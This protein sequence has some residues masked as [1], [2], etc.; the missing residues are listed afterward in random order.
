M[1]ISILLLA[2]SCSKEK[3]GHLDPYLYYPQNPM[4]IMQGRPFESFAINPNGSTR[5]MHVELVHIYDKVTG[6]NM[7]DIFNQKFPLKIWTA[8]YDHATDTTLDMINAIRKIVDT[9][10]IGI[11]LISGQLKANY[12]S[13]HLPLGD[14]TFDVK[15]SNV[16]GSTLY[17]KLGEFLLVSAPPYQK[18][19]EIGSPYDKL[20][21]VGNE[22]SVKSAKNP[23]ITIRRIA[24][25]PDV[26][27]VK[28]V[29][30]MGTA[31]NPK[32][33][34]IIKR[35]YPG[36]NPPQPYLQTMDDYAI[37][38]VYTDTSMDFYYP[39]VPFP[40]RSLGNGYNYYYRVPTRYAHIDKFPD[41]L[42]SLNPRFVARFFLPGAYEVTL[43]LPDVT[44]R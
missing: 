27:I 43:Q 15:I 12:N 19:P 28:F 24:D 34:E 32:A 11:D 40:V 36:N 10:A 35:P 1:G 39:V 23:I 7:D 25:T 13:Y 29:D 4:T 37:K 44:H 22:S 42:Y 30:K 38:H 6:K 17:P 26:I 3:I 31:F 41:D 14:Y 8:T 9:P 20:Y 21:Q 33:G 5:P 2:I 18:D 16:Y